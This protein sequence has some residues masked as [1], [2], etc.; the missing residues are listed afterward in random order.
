[1][2]AW[3]LKLTPAMGC[4]VPIPDVMGPHIRLLSSF[5]REGLG[6]PTKH[7]RSNISWCDQCDPKLTGLTMVHISHS[8]AQR[9]G[10]YS[11]QKKTKSMCLLPHRAH[12][13][14]LTS[15][16]PSGEPCA[17]CASIICRSVV[18]GPPVTQSI[19]A[20]GAW[21][22]LELEVPPPNMQL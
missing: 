13:A 20:A 21:L 16:P 6:M 14:H 18:G 2:R 10:S 3:F 1:M 7:L 22:G 8:V 11:K 5:T 19:V 17:C 4:H 9:P 12:R 15:L